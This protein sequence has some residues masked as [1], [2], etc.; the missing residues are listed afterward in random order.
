[1]ER[2]LGRNSGNSSMPP[3]SDTFGRPEKKLQR[4]HGHTAPPS[5]RT[6]H[7]R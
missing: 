2:R 5:V 7:S 1:M 4:P 6:T 3:S